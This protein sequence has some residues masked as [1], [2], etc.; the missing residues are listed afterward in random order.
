[1]QKKLMAKIV[2]FKQLA[3]KALHLIMN[4]FGDL[5]KLRESEGARRHTNLDSKTLE[6][7]TQ[8]TFTCSKSAI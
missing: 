7:L 3:A 8:K 6:A 5:L 1:M 4:K 2:C